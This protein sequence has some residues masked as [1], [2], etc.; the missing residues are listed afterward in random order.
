MNLE[1]L[2]ERVGGAMED[3]I[4]VRSP[5][6]ICPLGAHVDHQGGVVTGTALDRGVDLVLRPLDEPVIRIESLDFENPATVP[7]DGDLERRG[8]WGDYL[9]AAVTVLRRDHALSRGFSGAIR[10]DLPGMG[11]SSSAAVLVAYLLALDSVNGL[12][13]DRKTIARLAQRAE[14]EFIGLSSGLLDPSIILFAQTGHLT[15]IDCSDFSVDQIP[16]PAVHRNFGI[17]VVFSGISRRLA[18]TDY[19]SRVRQCREAAASLLEA[20]GLPL[21][22]EPRLGDVP[23][24]VFEAHGADL[25]DDQ[26]SV[27]V[28]YFG[29]TDRVHR[30]VEAWRRGDLESF[31][32]LINQSGESSVVNY[33]CGIP[34]LVA[35]WESLRESPGVFG[36]RFSGGGFGGSCLALIDP[37]AS[38]DVVERVTTAYREAFPKEA[39]A[40][41]AVLCRP[42]GAAS[43]IGR[44]NS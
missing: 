4:T 35:L 15:R 22:P 14:N 34:P 36:T 2:R 38:S 19:N 41:T 33:R 9:R 12:D 18:G 1:R 26:R 5:L 10:G 6:R 43:I 29:E 37:A 25:P 42:A 8:D 17:L 11:L 31:G 3:L 13:L 30:G 23:P 7:L 21:L 39:S 27:A 32:A 44:E 40:M 28:H 24:E 16:L 20:A